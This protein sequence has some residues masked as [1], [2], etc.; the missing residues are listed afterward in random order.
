MRHEYDSLC[1]NGDFGMQGLDFFKVSGTIN[2]ELDLA[3]VLIKKLA[4][5]IG[6]DSPA[7]V[8]LIEPIVGG[9]VGI[10]EFRAHRNQIGCNRCKDGCS[11]LHGDVMPPS[12]Q[13]LTQPIQFLGLDKRLTARDHNVTTPEPRDCLD[14]RRDSYFFILRRPARIR[15]VAPNAPQVAIAGPEKYGR[16][17]DKFPFALNGVE[18]FTVFH[19]ELNHTLHDYG[20]EI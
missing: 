4:Y 5:D 8:T 16:H 18:E 7:I 2:Y 13:L 20:V 1:G 10:S 12:I 19:V 11:R 9:G 15:S 17:T 6:T 14:R 3:L